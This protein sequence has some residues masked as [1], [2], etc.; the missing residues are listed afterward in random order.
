MTELKKLDDKSLLVESYLSEAKAYQS[1]SNLSKAKASLTQARSCA[2]QVFILPNLQ[3]EVDEVAGSILLE[4]GDSKIAHSYFHEALDG[5]IQCGEVSSAAKCLGFMLICVALQNENKQLLKQHH[6]IVLRLE[7][8]KKKTVTVTDDA[9]ADVENKENEEKSSKKKKKISM[10]GISQHPF[11]VMLEALTT[12]THESS[13][14]KFLQTLVDYAKTCAPPSLIPYITTSS[15]S[16]SLGLSG[17]GNNTVKTNNTHTEDDLFTIVT[18]GDKVLARS[19]KKLRDILLE[20]NL[21]KIIQPY[22]CVDIEYISKKIEL[23]LDI[24]QNKLSQLILDDRLYGTLDQGNG[25]LILNYKKEGDKSFNE[26]LNITNNLNNIVDIL[27]I[28]AKE[29]HN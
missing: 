2:A 1:L 6:R 24:V 8:N 21:I 5:Y 22:S 18:H 15:F 28:R 19:I 3:A 27:K 11:L 14:K 20:I 17:F 29:L 25:H 13:L 9:S 4:E 23:P 16:S 12:A 26:A 10:V 7:Q